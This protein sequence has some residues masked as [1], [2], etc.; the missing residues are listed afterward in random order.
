VPAAAPV[1]GEDFI[2][3]SERSW[4]R[5]AAKQERRR[6]LCEARGRRGHRKRSVK[7]AASVLRRRILGGLAAQ[8]HHLCFLLGCEIS[9]R[10]SQSPLQLLPSD[11]P[12]LLHSTMLAVAMA[13][14]PV[15]VNSSNRHCLPTKDSAASDPS[16]SR[17]TPVPSRRLPP[18]VLYPASS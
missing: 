15:T 13:A 7:R 12:L 2:D 10:A 16:T 1:P 18:H 11:W 3:T 9:T 4:K 5:Q 6:V 14:R 8:A 17:S